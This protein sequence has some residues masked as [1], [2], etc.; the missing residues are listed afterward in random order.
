MHHWQLH[1]YQIFIL[2]SAHIYSRN[3]S[4]AFVDSPIFSLSPVVCI[5]HLFKKSIVYKSKYT[6]SNMSAFKRVR[7]PICVCIKLP[8]MTGCTFALYQTYIKHENPRD[9]SGSLQHF[10]Y[11][12]ESISFPC[13]TVERSKSTVPKNLI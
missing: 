8:K 11:Y 12:L 9:H 2:N 13:S 3:T 10:P 1:S 4:F 7:R 6:T 5:F